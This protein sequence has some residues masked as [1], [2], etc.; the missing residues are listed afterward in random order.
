[1]L[2]VHVGVLRATDWYMLQSDYWQ[3]FPSQMSL[4]SSVDG[5]WS[6]KKKLVMVILLFMDSLTV[7]DASVWL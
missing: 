4:D 7:D 1:M 3:Q 2:Y 5:L 6:W